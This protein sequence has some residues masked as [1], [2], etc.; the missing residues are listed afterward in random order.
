[1][2]QPLVVT[3]PAGATDMD[4]AIPRPSTGSMGC[5]AVLSSLPVVST[6]EWSPSSTYKNNFNSHKKILLY[7]K[8][9]FN[10]HKKVF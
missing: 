2:T 4:P 6:T 5:S 1:M 3:S 10:S 9:Y 8:K 7:V